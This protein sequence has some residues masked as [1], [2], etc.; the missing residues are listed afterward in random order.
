MKEAIIGYFSTFIR[1]YT[2]LLSLDNRSNTNIIE[3]YKFV[4]QINISDAREGEGVYII[5][6]SILL[7]TTITYFT[8]NELNSIFL[9]QIHILVFLCNIV[10]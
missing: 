6:R 5:L 1:Y 10:E 8:E 2:H 9:Q 7:D 4:P 3:N